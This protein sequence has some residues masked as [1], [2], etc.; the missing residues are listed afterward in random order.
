[1]SWYHI[2]T[3]SH[4]AR[5][6]YLLYFPNEATGAELGLGLGLVRPAQHC[7]ARVRVLCPPHPSEGLQWQREDVGG[8]RLTSETSSFQEGSLSLS[9]LS[10]CRKRRLEG[11][12]RTSSVC[13]IGLSRPASCFHGFPGSQALPP[14]QSKSTV[15]RSE[16]KGQARGGLCPAW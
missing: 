10:F 6:Y 14:E 8:W 4:G 16:Q 2:D 7:Q 3:N 12:P 13:R 15:P 11:A 9:S 1:M 5:W